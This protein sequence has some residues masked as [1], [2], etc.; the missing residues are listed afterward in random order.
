MLR[1]WLRVVIPEPA[2]ILYRSIR[3]AGRRLARLLRGV[4]TCQVRGLTIKVGVAS[5]VEQY[6]ADSYASKEPETLD[7]LDQNLHEGDVFVDIGANI[8]LYSLYAAKR[9][10]TS[11]IFAIEPESQNFSRLCRNIVLNECSNIVPCNFPMAERHEFN[12]F[13]V[14]TF[15]E[16]AAL[17]SFGG[18]SRFQADSS[19][20]V[21]TQGAVSLSL[22]LLIEEYGWPYPALIKIDVDGLEAKIL[23]GARRV[24]E[25]GQV[26]TVLIEFNYGDAVSIDELEREFARRGFTLSQQGSAVW[27]LRGDKAQNVIFH[28]TN[29]RPGSVRTAV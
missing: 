15:E 3:R 12:L 18:V 13:Y 8:G 2:K 6:R 24:L 16:G 11:K 4:K 27:E 26:R 5:E 21:L 25:S 20:A 19:P 17:H 7:W 22:D 10:P 23:A 9:R 28:R 1:A 29:P 14:S